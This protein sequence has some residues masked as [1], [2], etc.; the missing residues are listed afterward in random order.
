[1]VVLLLIGLFLTALA[2]ALGARV[3]IASRLRAVDS[4]AGIDRYGFAGTIDHRRAHGIKETMEN[5]A[6]AIGN[7]ILRQLRFGNE[8]NVRRLIVSAGLYR[9]TPRM[10]IG[11]QVRL[12]LELLAM[13]LLVAAASIMSTKAVVIGTLLLPVL[14]YLAPPFYVR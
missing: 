13:V 3:V 14:G 9:L 8:D 4:L 10:L 12:G 7:L 1:M 11:Y 2:V 6:A 5:L